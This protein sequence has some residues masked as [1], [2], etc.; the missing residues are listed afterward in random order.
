MKVI[1]IDVGK[2]GS[3]VL[4][5]ESK[6]VLDFKAFDKI[7]PTKAILEIAQ[8]EHELKAVVEKVHAMPKQGVKSM[9]EF[10]KQLGMIIG[11]LDTLGIETELIPPATWMKHYK[12]F[13]GETAKER[14][15]TFIDDKYNLDKFILPRC[16]VPHSGIIDA[17]GLGCYYW[18]KILKKLW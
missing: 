15:A 18:D 11:T 10:G 16:R 2:K 3:V 8:N 1:S 14:V 12:D 6:E 13:Y 17:I 9:F 4:I 7:G 5:N